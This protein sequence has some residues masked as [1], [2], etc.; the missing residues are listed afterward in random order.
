MAALEIRIDLA[1]DWVPKKHKLTFW[2]MLVT[3]RLL[4]SQPVVHI[5]IDGR[6]QRNRLAIPHL[7]EPNHTIRKIDLAPFEFEESPLAITDVVRNDEHALQRVWQFGEHLL[8]P[9][10]VKKT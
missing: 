1:I 4:A 8:V 6:C 5:S 3:I 7:H 2:K 10:K 9:I